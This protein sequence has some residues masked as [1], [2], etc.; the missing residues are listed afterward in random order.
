MVVN[1]VKHPH[2]KTELA[3]TFVDWVVSPAGQAAITSYKIGGERLFFP[4]AR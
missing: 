4:N 1:P 3:Q 2:V